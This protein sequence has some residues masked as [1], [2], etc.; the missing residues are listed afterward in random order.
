MDYNHLM[1]GAYGQKAI[2]KSVDGSRTIHGAREDFSKFTNISKN[3]SDLDQPALPTPQIEAGIY[4]L[5]GKGNYR[6][7]FSALRCDWTQKY[8]TQHQLLEFYKQLHNWMQGDRHAL[9]LVKKDEN[10]LLSEDYPEGNLVVVHIISSG[11]PQE[12]IFWTPL[13]SFNIIEGRNYN[14]QPPPY[15]VVPELH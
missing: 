2:I 4:P 9:F 11:Y 5:K 13:D 8:F 3:F 15:L 1:L 14:G 12:E 7:I 10:K 6:T